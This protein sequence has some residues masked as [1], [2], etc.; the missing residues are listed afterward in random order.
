MIR[1]SPASSFMLKPAVLSVVLMASATKR[2]SRVLGSSEKFVTVS[3]LR[4]ALVSTITGRVCPILPS[5]QLAATG[6]MNDPSELAW[7][8][9]T[10]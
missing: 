10:P 6:K 4:N 7:S 2:K 3:S 5:S 9:I 1:C 8:L